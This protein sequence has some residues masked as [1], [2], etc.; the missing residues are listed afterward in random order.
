MSDQDRVRR[1][2]LRDFARSDAGYET[3][4][5]FGRGDSDAADHATMTLRP[6]N[7][8]EL[9]TV[10]ARSFPPFDGGSGRMLLLTVD[11]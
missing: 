3:L 9:I 7:R 5:Q 10:D 6:S 8:D 11:R 1:R 4:R 2:P